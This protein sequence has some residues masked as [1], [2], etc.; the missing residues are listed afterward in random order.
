[1]RRERQA[2]TS[3]HLFYRTVYEDHRFKC[4]KFQEW[5]KN[6]SYSKPYTLFDML[7]I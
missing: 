7:L 6:K 5:I 2:L 4:L 1:M 3:T